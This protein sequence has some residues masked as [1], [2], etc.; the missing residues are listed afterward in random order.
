MAEPA[1]KPMTLEEFF[2]WDDGTETHYE[3]IG[4]FPVAMAPPAAAHRI[5]VA[6]LVSRLEASL[7]HRRPCNAQGEAGIVPLTERI[8]ISKPILRRHSSTMNLGSRHSTI[9]S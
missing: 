5:L 9:L 7:A 8:L 3:L 1:W 2:H 4:G 6:R